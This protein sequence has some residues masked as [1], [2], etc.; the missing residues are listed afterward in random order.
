MLLSYTAGFVHDAS[1]GG[2]CDHPE[3]SFEKYSASISETWLDTSYKYDPACRLSNLY[4][5]LDLLERK[6]TH[7]TRTGYALCPSVS[8]D[9][10]HAVSI[11]LQ[12][13][14]CSSHPVAWGLLPK[15]WHRI[16]GSESIRAAEEEG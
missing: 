15:T 2:N 13:I 9:I 7:L 11:L 5:I 10:F 3:Y 16:C 1:Y 12:S 4:K 8:F 6:R 14:S